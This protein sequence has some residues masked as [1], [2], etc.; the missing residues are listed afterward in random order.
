ML[1]REENGR[2][3][4]ASKKEDSIDV[5]C[6]GAYTHTSGKVEE[7][8]VISRVRTWL[9]IYDLGLDGSKEGFLIMIPQL[10]FQQEYYWEKVCLNLSSSD[11]VEM[12]VS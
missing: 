11:R 5:F 1:S 12:W 8:Q 3:M 9:F 10:E 2:S 6:E 4:Q 7:F